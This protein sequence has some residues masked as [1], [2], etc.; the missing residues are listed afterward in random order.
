[1]LQVPGVA[2]HRPSVL[3]GDHL[4]VTLAEERGQSP[5]VQYKGY[6]HAVELEQVKLGFSLKWVTSFF[7]VACANGLDPLALEIELRLL[8][9]VWLH[10]VL[11]IA[12][13]AG[14][15]EGSTLVTWDAAI[16][17][18]IIC[19]AFP[20]HL[21]VNNKWVSFGGQELACLDISDLCFLDSLFFQG[22]Y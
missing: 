20:C 15:G 16:S 6:V 7:L 4:F 14:S 3:K 1:M 9:Q 19:P 17:C 22:K 10:G 12:L 2:E 11:S 5:S 8:N 18:A 21:T 13:F